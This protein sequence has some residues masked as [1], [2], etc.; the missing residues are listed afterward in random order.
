MV[1]N[2]LPHQHN[3]NEIMKC[4]QNI[5]LLCKWFHF[6]WKFRDC[7]VHICF[8]YICIACT[9]LALFQ[10]L[11]LPVKNGNVYK[12]NFRTSN[13]F[14][15]RIKRQ[16]H[17]ES[18]VVP[19]KARNSES[20]EWQIS[21]LNTELSVISVSIFDF[22]CVTSFLY[23]NTLKIVSNL[24]LILKSKYYYAENKRISHC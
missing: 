12:N 17:V 9:L 7:C 15:A 19:N 11:K 4:L 6:S 2:K 22:L 5:F 21:T 13:L 18:C 1:S 23:L 16:T 14:D 20:Y 10:L 24:S 3:I 8:R